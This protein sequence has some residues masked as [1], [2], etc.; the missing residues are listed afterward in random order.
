VFDYIIEAN[1]ASPGEWLIG[2]GVYDVS[3]G[4][5]EFGDLGFGPFVIP[6]GGLELEADL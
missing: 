6:D 3:V 1:S 5:L 2:S 4:D